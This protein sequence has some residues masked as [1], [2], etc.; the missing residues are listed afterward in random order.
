[1]TRVIVKIVGEEFSFLAVGPTDFAAKG[2]DIVCAGISSLCMALDSRLQELESV[3]KATISDRDIS[4]A[5]FW[6]SF[7]GFAA[8]ETLLTVIAGLNS[9][10]GDYPNNL[11][12]KVVI[13]S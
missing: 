7:T 4:D 13:A 1:M 2:K 12:V 3:G 6:I 11:I 8:K 9:I 5:Q 10:A